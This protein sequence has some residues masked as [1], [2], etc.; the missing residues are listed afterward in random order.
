MAAQICEWNGEVPYC[1]PVLSE[2]DLGRDRSV[3]RLAAVGVSGLPAN[4]AVEVN[5]VFEISS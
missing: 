5:A 3:V 1:G 2:G 4:A